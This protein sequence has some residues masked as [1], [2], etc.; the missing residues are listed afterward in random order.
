M[1]DAGTTVAQ[2]HPLW[3]AGQVRNDVVNVDGRVGEKL[4]RNDGERLQWRRGVSAGNLRGMNPHY[5]RSLPL[6][7]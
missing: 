1:R 5:V 6:Y 3:I 4:R 2:P 7:S